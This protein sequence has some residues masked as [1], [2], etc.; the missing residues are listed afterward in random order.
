MNLK[1]NVT[2]HKNSL[3]AILL[4]ILILAGATVLFGASSKKTVSEQPPLV[5]TKVIKL[6]DTDSAAI[7]S[8]E[9]RGRYERSLAFQVS[10]KIIRRNVELGNT[11]SAGDILM[12][13][14]PKDVQ[15]TVNIT[16]AQVTAA[17]SQLT[18]AESNLERYRALF[19]EGAVSR[20]VYDQYVTAHA[21]A[22]AAA[23]QASAQYTQ[24]SN[25]LEYTALRAPS[26]G[27]ISSINAEAGQVVA[28]GQIILTL[29]QDGEREIEMEIPENRYE[30]IRNARRI[31]V[32]FWALPDRT[33]EGSVREMAPIADKISRTYKVRIQLVN[34][35]PELKLGM[36]ASVSVAAAGQQTAVQIPLSAIYQT[37]SSPSVWVVK[38][39]TATLRP[40]KVGTF[41]DGS[42]QVLEGLAD[43]DIIIPAGVHKLKEGQKVRLAGEKI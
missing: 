8:G 9:V 15:Q 11:V 19:E 17:Q 20:A 25:Q 18:L 41:G 33:V 42:V 28:A 1:S 32:S 36:T 13:I 31:Q 7:Y 2:S 12:E 24:G 38:N 26:A 30:A 40:V 14:D 22:L 35:P 29:V 4:F 6:N 34:P 23:R 43:K 39:D 37:G 16:A 3:I 21:A 27:V 10:G 5:R